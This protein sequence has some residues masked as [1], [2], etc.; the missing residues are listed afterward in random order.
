MGSS[1]RWPGISAMAFLASQF[2][3]CDLRSSVHHLGDM[4]RW[5]DE[6]AF[7]Y[8]SLNGTPLLDIYLKG[9]VDSWKGLQE[10]Y[11][12]ELIEVR[13]DIAPH[14]HANSDGVMLCG[15]GAAHH[16][17]YLP[18][19]S[20]SWAPL[21]AHQLIPIPRG[22]VHGFKADRRLGLDYPFHVFAVNSPSIPEGDTHYV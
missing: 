1:D 7:R 14:F 2:I 9:Y 3:S 5:E 15:F 4:V 21:K 6:G 10:D 18:E 17:T 16:L 19:G 13:G 12:F 22:T 8:C 11:A 20:G